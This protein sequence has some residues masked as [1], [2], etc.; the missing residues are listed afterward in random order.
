PAFSDPELHPVPSRN[1]VDAA[2]VEGGGVDSTGRR[3][4]VAGDEPD[5]EL[6]VE[7]LDCSR[8][9]DGILVWRR[10]RSLQVVGRL[11]GGGTRAPC[12]PPIGRALARWR[13]AL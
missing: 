8:R 9:A 2:G 4:V 13:C 12:T 5:A 7:P 6:G 1:R 11:N 10:H 3:A